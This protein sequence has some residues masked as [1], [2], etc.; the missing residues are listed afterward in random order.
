[1]QCETFRDDML[2]VLY[3]EAEPAAA[4]RFEA[5]RSGCPDCAEEVA[6]LRR[7]RKTLSAWTVPE[8][9]RARGGWRPWR[10]LAAA[11]ALLLALGGGLGLAGVHFKY[12]RGPLAVSLGRSGEDLRAL[13][14]EQE[15]RHRQELAALE[16]RL[17]PALPHD[18]AALLTRVEAMIR[19][20]EARQALALNASLRELGEQTEIQRRY[21]LARVSAGLSYLEGKTGQQVARTTELMGYVLQASQQK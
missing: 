1:M 5:H 21:D 8:R 14:A 15:G 4:A 11:A 9:A 13:L 2:S 17:A 16:T 6:A 10:W 3:G 20:A 18:D 12:A 19:D 7:L